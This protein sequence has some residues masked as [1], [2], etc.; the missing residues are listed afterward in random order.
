VGGLGRIHYDLGFAV[1]AVLRYVNPCLGLPYRVRC[2]RPSECRPNEIYFGHCVGRVI[3]RSVQLCPIGSTFVRTA[4]IRYVP[5]AV[6][7]MEVEHLQQFSDM[8]TLVRVCRVAR[9]ARF[10]QIADRNEF[11]SLCRERDS[12]NVQ[13]RPLGSTFVRTAII[14]ST[15]RA[16]GLMQIENLIRYA[17]LAVGLNKAL[18]YARQ[19]P[20]ARAIP[21]LQRF[22][23]TLT[24]VRVCRVE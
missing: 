12:A 11:R 5:R 6:G 16:V 24:L 4:K 7:L 2:P 14:R 22:S 20:P 3:P 17:P 23:V 10:R 19:S 8:L 13:P 21:D 18:G 9:G 15:E 1:I